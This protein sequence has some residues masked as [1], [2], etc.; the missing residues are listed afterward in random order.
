M[1]R[2]TQLES[3]KGELVGRETN[4]KEQIDSLS[5]EKNKQEQYLKD[6]IQSERL[7]ATKDIQE[8]RQKLVQKED[9]SKDQERSLMFKESEFD[10]TMALY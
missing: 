10:K 3:E 2:I 8:L 5:M 1:V 7:R 9:T 4:M 6:E